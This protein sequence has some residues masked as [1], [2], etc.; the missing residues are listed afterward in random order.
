MCVYHHPWR[1]ACSFYDFITV[2]SVTVIQACSVCSWALI[3]HIQRARSLSPIKSVHAPCAAGVTRLTSLLTDVRAAMRALL[4]EIVCHLS[5][6]MVT[7]LPLSHAPWTPGCLVRTLGV[8]HPFDWFSA[9][10]FRC[11]CDVR[12][13]PVNSKDREYRV[14]KEVMLTPGGFILRSLL[15]LSYLPLLSF[16]LFLK[17]KRK[18]I[19]VNTASLCWKLASFS[20]FSLFFF[21][22]KG[23]ASGGRASLCEV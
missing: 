23:Q 18:Y 11:H 5:N 9:L 13:G 7:C 20:F 2:T 1:W 4:E 8:G 19:I 6:S 22:L 3:P 17:Q 15:F 21:C 16:S 12:V 10:V 14:D